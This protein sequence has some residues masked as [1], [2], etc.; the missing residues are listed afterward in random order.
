MRKALNPAALGCTKHD[1]RRLTGALREESD[2]RTLR[3]LQAVLLVAEGHDF[4]TSARLTGFSRRSLYRFVSRYLDAHQV[5]ALRDEER[6]GRPATAP[7]LT[8]ARILHALERAPRRLGYRTNVWTVELLAEHLN[9]RHGC[10]IR[11]RTCGGGCARP[12]YAVNAPA[13]S[14]PRRSRT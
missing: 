7:Q 11:P 13:M 6:S 8:A 10:A 9:E 12:A 4:T 3:R 1:G 5:S 14:T 2:A